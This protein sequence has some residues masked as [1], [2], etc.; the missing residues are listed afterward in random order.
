MLRSLA[1]AYLKGELED[2]R[3]ESMDNPHVVRALE[4]IKGVGRWSAEY[5]LLYS[6]GRLDVYP[7]DDVG[8]AKSLATWLGI[9]GR[10]SYEDVQTVTS[11]WG[12][13]R[14]MVYFHLLLRRLREKSLV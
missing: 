14:G 8:A 1:S 9:S 11:R 10:L 12:Q 4:G 7:G 5:V 2:V 13:Y 6:L 3:F